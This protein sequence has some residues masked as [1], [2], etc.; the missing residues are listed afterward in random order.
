MFTPPR[1]VVIDDKPEHLDAILDVFQELGAPCQGVT[2]DPEHGLDNRHLAGVRVL[3]V[4]LHESP[5][6][7]VGRGGASWMPPQ[8]RNSIEMSAPCEWKP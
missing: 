8:Q 7:R 4:D 6:T 3:F 2:Y 1:F 5:Q